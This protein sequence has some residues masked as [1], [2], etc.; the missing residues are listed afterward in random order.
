MENQ[1]PKLQVYVKDPQNLVRRDPFAGEGYGML[2]TALSYHRS[3]ETITAL[4]LRGRGHKTNRGLL[5]G[6]DS[7]EDGL[8]RGLTC[9]KG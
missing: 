4:T 9:I 7:F 8:S 6:L 3:C 5:C 2:L 1:R